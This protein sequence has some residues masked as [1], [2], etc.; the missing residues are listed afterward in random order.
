MAATLIACG[1]GGGESGGGSTGL[2]SKPVDTTKQAVK[3]GVMQ[4]WYGSEGINF[5]APSGTS[6]VNFH[7]GH[8]YSTMIKNKVG[9]AVAKLAPRLGDKMS[10]KRVDQQHYEEAPRHPEGTLF[11]PSESTGIV[12]TTHGPG[13]P[14]P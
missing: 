11:Q 2:V 3:G 14:K 4:G 12:G 5:D 8:T 10:A 7:S 13:G 6:N 9:T 1:G